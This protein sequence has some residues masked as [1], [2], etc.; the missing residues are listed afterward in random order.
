MSFSPAQDRPWLVVDDLG[1][2]RL[3]NWAA[4]VLFPI[5]NARCIARAHTPVANNVRPE[6]LAEPCLRSRFLDVALCH[7]VPNG[8]DGYR[9][10][11]NRT[12]ARD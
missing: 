7:R 4:E 3:T 1:A 11:K 9:Q 10:G 2:E 12:E 5:F 8:G 6:D